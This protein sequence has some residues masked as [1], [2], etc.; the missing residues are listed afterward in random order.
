MAVAPYVIA[1][2]GGQSALARLIGK[3]SSTVQY[4]AMTGVVPA[5]W[6]AELLR[7]AAERGIDLSP[8]DFMPA[9]S[10]PDTQPAVAP[11][12]KWW[13][14]LAIGTMELPVYVLDDGRRVI[15]R[16]GAVAVLIGPQG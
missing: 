14:T 10:D 3:G 13:G 16:T 1:K 5:R 15:S 2:F 7:L 4:W 9:I 6:Q 11:E 12:A 8:R